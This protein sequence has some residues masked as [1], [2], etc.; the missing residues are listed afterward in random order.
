MSGYPDGAPIKSGAGAHI[1]I[2]NGMTA[3][4]ALLIALDHRVRTGEGQFIDLSEWEVPCSLTGEA[5]LD[6]SMNRRNPPRRGNRDDVMAPHNCYPCQGEDK[7]VSIAVATEEEWQAFCGA[8][9]NP[10]WTERGEFSDAFSRMKNREDL[11]KLIGE[12]TKQ[13]THY[14][15]MNILQKVGVAAIPS[16][17]QAELFS[18]P[19]IRER[20]CW[21]EVE[22]PEAG[23]NVALNP[24]WKL[25]ETP[26]RITRHAPLVGEHNERIFLELLGIPIEEFAELVGGEVLY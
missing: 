1:D 24:T 15:V 23:K 26:A 18:D 14:E 22:H 9:G 5:F 17:D 21:A 20:D 11:D 7:W 13:Y 6:F 4:A 2:I 19:H 10:E 25:S 16:F 8:M 3:A 12:W